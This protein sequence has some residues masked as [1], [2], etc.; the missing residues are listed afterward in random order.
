MCE[1]SET[2]R[3]TESSEAG[4]GWLLK[5]QG[6]GNTFRE[7]KHARESKTERIQIIEDPAQKVTS[8]V[9]PSRPPAECIAFTPVLLYSHMLL[10][11]CTRAPWVMEA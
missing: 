6:L 2:D 7:P 5:I 3:E 11:A 10:P 4:G 9:T 1:G 8:S